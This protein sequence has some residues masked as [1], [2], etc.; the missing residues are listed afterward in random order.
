[1]QRQIIQIDEERC[2]GCGQCVPSCA[3][4]AIR[5]V[6]GKAR[7]VAEKF[8]DGLGACLGECPVGALK[9]IERE[10]EDFDEGA[11]EEHLRKIWPAPAGRAPASGSSEPGPSGGKKMA[12]FL[13]QGIKAIIDQFPEVGKILEEFQIGCTAC[14]AGS[15]LLKDVVEIHN[16]PPEDER[17][18]MI[19]IARVI[20]P[21]G[22]FDPPPVKRAGAGK[23]KEIRYSPPMKKLV[24]EHLWIKRWV[25]L[26]PAVLRDLDLRDESGRARILAGLDFIRSYADRFH[27]AKEEEILFKYFDENLDIIKVMLEDHRSARGHV[28]AAF[29]AVERREARAVREHLRAYAELLSEHI[30]KEDEILYPWMDRQLSTS[31]VGELYG[32]FAAAE[33]EIGYSP[34]KYEGLVAEWEEKIKSEEG[35]NHE[36]ICRMPEFQNA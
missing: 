2:N 30:K 25:A 8:C 4:G 1:M 27:H 20:D 33:S 14:A 23:P 17:S 9:V 5:I 19:R 29:E 21:N 31:K 28:Q 11:V 32:K 16:L 34:K 18:V 22:K 13:N 35:K 3:E 26:I 7:L 36:G 12:D 24:D 6:E 10:A 15:C